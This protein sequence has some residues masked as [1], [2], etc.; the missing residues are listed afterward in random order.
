MP[1]LSLRHDRLLFHFGSTPTIDIEP[2]YLRPMTKKAQFGKTELGFGHKG[3]LHLFGGTYSEDV[4]NILDNN[5]C[6]FNKLKTRTHKIFFLVTNA[7]SVVEG[8]EM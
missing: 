4:K 6:R 1:E 5:S 8:M 3:I 2:L 7:A